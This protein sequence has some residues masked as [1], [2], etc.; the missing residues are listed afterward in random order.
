MFAVEVRRENDYRTK[1]DRAIVAKIAD[2]FAASTLVVWDV[3]LL[4][5]VVIAKYSAPDLATPQIFKRGEVADAEPA[6]PGW[7]IPVDA[8]FPR[9]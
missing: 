3:D 5:E 2:Y 7:T 1:A 6:V 4:G 8:L 9:P